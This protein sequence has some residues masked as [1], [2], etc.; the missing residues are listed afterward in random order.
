[1]LSRLRGRLPAVASIAAAAAATTAAATAISTTTAAA[2][3]TTA[4]AA[5]A[6]AA[7]LA[8]LSLVHAE[9]ATVED[10]AVHPL[11]RGGCV[12]GGA[13]RDEREATR[14]AALAVGDDVHVRDLSGLGERRAHGVEGRVERKVAD[15][16]S[17]THSLLSLSFRVGTA[18]ARA[19]PNF[20]RA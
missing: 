1:M 9:R 3:T 8:L 17:V 6:T 2:P 13:H 14:A 4:A 20:E 11:D 18:G 10:R 7:R 15:V 12:L 16:E 5:A 19:S